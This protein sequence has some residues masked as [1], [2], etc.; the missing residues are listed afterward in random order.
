MQEEEEGQEF[1]F[2]FDFEETTHEPIYI[3]SAKQ[4]TD[5]KSLLS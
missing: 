2:F 3:R 5:A 4:T 1:T